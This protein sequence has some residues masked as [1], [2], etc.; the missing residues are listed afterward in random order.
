MNMVKIDEYYNK[1]T[2][3]EDNFNDIMLTSCQESRKPTHSPFDGGKIKR[4]IP[5]P[6]D[7][8][9]LKKV[10]FYRDNQIHNFDCEFATG[11]SCICWCGEKYHGGMGIGAKV[12]STLE[13]NGCVEK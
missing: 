6:C 13:T 4:H 1:D 12:I 11:R 2:T 8:E 7:L 3:E 9:E 5:I 10:T